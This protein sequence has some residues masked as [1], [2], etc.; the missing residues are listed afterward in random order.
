M[1]IFK[2]NMNVNKIRL[3][4]L[5]LN[6]LKE[7]SGVCLVFGVYGISTFVVYLIPNPFLY[8]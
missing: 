2:A 1:N 5:K 8:K 7:K 6:E 4:F 3:I